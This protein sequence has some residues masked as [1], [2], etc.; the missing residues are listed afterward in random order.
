MLSYHFARLASFLACLLPGSL[1]EIIGRGLGTLAWMVIPK[2]RKAMARENV[3]LCLGVGEAEAD[4]IIQNAEAEKA[5]R[6]AEA[7]GQVARFA[8]MYEEYA[9]NPE[10]TRQRLYYEVLE[11]ILPGIKIYITD[12]DTQTMLPLEPF[13]SAAATQEVS[14]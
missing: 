1:A 3:R 8:K 6:I 2:W 9:N 14:D 10:V 11:E 13:N 4:R 12:G 7:E 5:A